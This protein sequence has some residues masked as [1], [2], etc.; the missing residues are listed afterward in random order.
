M[1]EDDA[2]IWGTQTFDS[3]DAN[4]VVYGHGGNFSV[5]HI[6]DGTKINNV[7]V[8]DAVADHGIAVSDEREVAGNRRIDAQKTPCRRPAHKSVRRMLHHQESEH[9]E[10]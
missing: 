4:A 2:A 5:P 9:A 3:L 6:G 10:G 8:M 7:A 1:C